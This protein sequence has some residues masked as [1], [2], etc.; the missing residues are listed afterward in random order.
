MS[1]AAAMRSSSQSS[2]PR[3]KDT[4]GVSI[5]FDAAGTAALG[6]KATQLLTEK[7]LTAGPSGIAM[8][9]LRKFLFPEHLENADSTGRL[10]LFA[11]Y[12]PTDDFGRLHGG[13]AGAHIHTDLEI[14]QMI[15]HNCREA[16][17][18]CFNK[19]RDTVEVVVDTLQKVAM[20]HRYTDQEVQRL[21]KDIDRGP[22]G[23]MNFSAMQHTILASQKERL[24]AIVA[25]VEGGK[26]LNPP[27]ERPTKVPFHHRSAATL[28][29][30]TQKK[31]FNDQE[32]QVANLKRLHAFGTLI[33]GLEQQNEGA[34]LRGNVMLMRHPHN[35]SDKWD[36]Y[37]ALKRT[38][39]SSYVGARNEGRFNASMDD[40]LSN[41]HPGVS[42]LLAAGAAGSSAAAQL[43]A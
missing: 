16:L 33:A 31:K 17:F 27:K 8:P 9:S 3:G 35:I 18:A 26:P 14:A 20:T 22:D 43:A 1:A 39:R 11:R 32:E 13:P 4:L 12:G 28:L 30:I 37:C 7:A 21:L 5:S 36:R 19:P 24:K 15:R 41:K 29:S 38:G 42:S 10:E 6:K 23:R 25:R 2:M 34:Q 40:G